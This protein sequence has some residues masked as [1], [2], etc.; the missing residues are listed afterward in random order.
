MG[1]I[2]SDGNGGYWISKGMMGF[3]AIVVTV[4]L[5]FAGNGIAEYNRDYDNLVAAEK[6]HDARLAKLETAVVNIQNNREDIK[7]IRQDM[8]DMNKKLD[9]IAQIRR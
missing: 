8:K 3:F 9:S 4:L 6:E 5:F 1:G 7:E 2:K